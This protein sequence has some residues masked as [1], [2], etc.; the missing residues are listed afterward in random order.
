MSTDDVHINALPLVKSACT[1]LTCAFPDVNIVT[2]N[3]QALVECVINFE[4]WDKRN[5][6]RNKYAAVRIKYSLD[7]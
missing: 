5:P 6:I 7:R 4:K 3:A 2:V 1:C